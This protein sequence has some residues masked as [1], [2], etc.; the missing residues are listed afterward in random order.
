[1]LTTNR[2]Q[3]MRRLEHLRAQPPKKRLQAM[4]R[5]KHLR[6]QPPKKPV[7]AMRRGEHL[8]A[9]PIMSLTSIIKSNILLCRCMCLSVQILSLHSELLLYPS[10]TSRGVEEGVCNETDLNACF[11]VIRVYSKRFENPKI[12]PLCLRLVLHLDYDNFDLN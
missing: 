5:V 8:R 1:M 10:M 9:Q 3:A 6:A 2:V 4:R 7:Q 12:S 11:R